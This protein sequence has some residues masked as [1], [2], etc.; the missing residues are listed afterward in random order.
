MSCRIVLILVFLS[1]N[2]YSQ[3]DE[4]SNYDIKIIEYLNTE[5]G[6]DRMI[7]KK[8]ST[9]N[10]F[11]CRD[12]FGL[13]LKSFDYSL[14]QMR[15][16]SLK[17]FYDSIKV[18]PYITQFIKLHSESYKLYYPSN[19]VRFYDSNST[20]SYK[21]KGVFIHFSNEMKFENLS[22][23]W[24]RLDISSV[25]Y[26]SDGFFVFNKEQEIIHVFGNAAIL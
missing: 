4:Y 23:V 15:V 13:S 19:T 21:D 2:L 9:V 10:V 26:F 11:F 22:I 5:N 12:Q 20:G 16:D 1:C 14:N 25:N 7:L 8:D 6:Y 17:Q 3:I 18:L 24:M